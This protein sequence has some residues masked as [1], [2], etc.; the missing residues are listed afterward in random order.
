MD[1]YCCNISHHLKKDIYSKMKFRLIVFLLFVSV[2]SMLS[3]Q[4]SAGTALLKSAVIP[5]WGEYSLGHTDRAQSFWLREGAIWLAFVGSRS[6]ENWYRSDMEGLASLHAGT[7]ISSRSSE[8]AV[9]IGDFDSFEEYNAM[10]VRTR[11]ID[12]I[13]PEN[14]GFE[15]EWD[16][17]ANREKYD[18]IRMKSVSA[19]K[20][21]AFMIGGMVLHRVISMMDIIY[22]SRSESSQGLQSSFYPSSSKTLTWSLS[23]G[24]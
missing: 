22:L 20:F 9:D 12:R 19:E 23:Y 21:A 16:S 18:D 11:S 2:F 1:Q 14:L 10:M 4:Q 13:Y 24:F 3:A 17:P 8:Y 5:G 6:M 15:W 7:N